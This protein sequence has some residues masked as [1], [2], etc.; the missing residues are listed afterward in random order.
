M[1]PEEQGWEQAGARGRE[2]CTVFGE[3]FTSGGGG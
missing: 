2:Y 1:G 3:G